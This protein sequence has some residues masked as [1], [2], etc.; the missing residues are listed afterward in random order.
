MTMPELTKENPF[1]K[2]A[3]YSSEFWVRR[4]VESIVAGLCD[5][6]RDGLWNARFSEYHARP[7]ELADRLVRFVID[8]VLGYARKTTP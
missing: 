3:R 5:G 2:W 7:Q 4:A 8:D 6:A 1:E